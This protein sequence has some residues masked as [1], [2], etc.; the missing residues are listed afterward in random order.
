[1]NPGYHNIVMQIHDEEGGILSE[2]TVVLIES[3]DDEGVKSAL[4]AAY[5]NL[6]QQAYGT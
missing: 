1:M 5:K 3:V 4:L 2:M 6:I